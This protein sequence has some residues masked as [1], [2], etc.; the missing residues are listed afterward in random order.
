MLDILFRPAYEYTVLE[1]KI[2]KIL[3]M[4]IMISGGNNLTNIPHFLKR[5]FQ[6]ITRRR[7]KLETESNEFN[8][9]FHVYFKKDFNHKDEIKFLEMFSP[10][11]M[12]K[13]TEETKGRKSTSINFEMKENTVILY[14]NSLVRWSMP[15]P[16][17]L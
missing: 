12:A 5:K 3:P 8:Q 17:M 7:E 9:R 1:V 2:K 15:G 10:E 6:L 16:S 14:K 4:V 13:L 11:I